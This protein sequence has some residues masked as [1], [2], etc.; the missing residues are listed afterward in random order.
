V[1]LVYERDEAG[2]L[3]EV[4]VPRRPG[5]APAGRIQARYEGSQ[6]AVVHPEIGRRITLRRHYEAQGCRVVTCPGPGLVSSCPI[7][8]GGDIRECSLLQRPP[9]V[10]VVDLLLS[11][12]RLAPTYA[13][14]FPGTEIVI[15]HDPR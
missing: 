14:T 11:R 5:H 9:D 10:L 7:A 1:K 3:Q 15:E 8:R 13:E 12:W 4:F 2:R 6:V